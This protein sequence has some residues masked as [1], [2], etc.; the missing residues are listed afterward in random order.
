[1][2]VDKVKYRLEQLDQEESETK[3]LRVTQKE[4]VDGIDKFHADL[5]ETWENDKRVKSLKT[6]IRVIQRTQR[7]STRNKQIHMK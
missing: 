1:M 7:V 6:A 5:I 3:M 2:P 4:Y